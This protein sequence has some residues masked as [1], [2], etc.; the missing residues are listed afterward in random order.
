VVVGNH[1]LYAIRRVPRS[2]HAFAFP[3]DWY[4]LE[5]EERRARSGGRVWLYE[6]ESPTTKLTRAERYYLESLP[7]Y[8]PLTW[9]SCG[10]YLSHSCHPDVTGSLMLRAHNPWEMRGH[11][12][13]LKS[14]GCS[15]GFSGHMHPN[16]VVVIREEGMREAP[17]GLLPLG[18]GPVQFSCPGIADGGRR[19]GYAIVDSNALTIEAFPLHERKGM[20]ETWYERLLRKS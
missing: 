6:T 19:Q 7:E 3:T 17:F 20:R 10:V 5:V 8:L 16:G 18:D 15:Y 9:G 12:Q 14:L 4:E 1:D 11:L 13:E 2:E